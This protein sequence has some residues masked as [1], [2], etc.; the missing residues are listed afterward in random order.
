MLFQTGSGAVRP[1]QTKRHILYQGC[2]CVVHAI[3]TICVLFLVCYSILNASC[4][5]S[6][7]QLRYDLIDHLAVSLA[8]QLWHNSL[9]DLSFV[10]RSDQVCMFLCKVSLD[11]RSVHQLWSVFRN[12]IISCLIFIFQILSGFRTGVD[13]L[14]P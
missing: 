5:K 13:L 14:F 12:H 2:E 8:L 11:L 3:F 10:S 1:R 9:H 6:F 7:A 4:E